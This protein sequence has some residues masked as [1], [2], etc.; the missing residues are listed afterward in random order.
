MSLP[1]L[2][3]LFLLSSPVL[4][5]GQVTASSCS[6]ACRPSASCCGEAQCSGQD[7]TDQSYLSKVSPAVSCRVNIVVT[8]GCPC[9]IPPAEIC[10]APGAELVLSCDPGGEC[11]DHCSWDTPQGSCSWADGS[12]HCSDP[13]V[14]P[15]LSGGNCNLQITSVD[16]RH[17]GLWKCKVVP[18]TLALS[19][20]S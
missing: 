10:V 20:G 11:I 19:G 17:S 9:M 4:Q 3:L 6:A 2:S 16:Y 1:A 14:S 18:S 7:P 15:V 8:A 5:P 13:T 12:V